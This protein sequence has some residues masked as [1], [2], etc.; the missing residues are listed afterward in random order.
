MASSRLCWSWFRPV[1]GDEIIRGGLWEEEE[2]RGGRIQ[3]AKGTNTE[4]REKEKRKE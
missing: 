1:G 3:K 2:E 4:E